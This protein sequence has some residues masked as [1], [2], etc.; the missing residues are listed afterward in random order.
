MQTERV[1]V[2]GHASCYHKTS[3]SRFRAELVFE[4]LIVRSKNLQGYWYT[5]DLYECPECGAKIRMEHS[6]GVSNSGHGIY[7]I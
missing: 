7:H 3:C 4:D 2:G 6:L 1:Y 5:F